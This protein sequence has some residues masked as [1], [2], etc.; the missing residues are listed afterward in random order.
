MT[1]PATLSRAEA[2]RL[3]TLVARV[4]TIRHTLDCARRNERTLTAELIRRMRA[5][6]LD[7]VD[8]GA[9][10][11]VLDRP[12]REFVDPTQVDVLVRDASIHGVDLDPAVH[13]ALPFVDLR[14]ARDLVAGNAA[15]ERVL[16]A[17]VLELRSA[18]RVRILSARRT[19]RARRG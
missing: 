11:A 2:W 10:R 18:P 15:A 5:A 9:L 12:R 7:T 13:H 6:D 16:S 8:S 4:D 1:A 3:R 19:R 17:H 14:M